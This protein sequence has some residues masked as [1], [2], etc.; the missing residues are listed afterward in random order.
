[1]ASP[2]N[3]PAISK[4]KLQKILIMLGL[5]CLVATAIALPLAL[6]CGHGGGNNNSAAQKVALLYYYRQA[7][8][9]QPTPQPAYQPPVPQQQGPVKPPR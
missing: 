4:S 8:L 7:Q 2:S 3:T 5:G 1:T 9:P 6:C